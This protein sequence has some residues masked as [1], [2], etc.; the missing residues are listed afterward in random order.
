MN[1]IKIV[2][3]APYY[4][5]VID[6]IVHK[7]TFSD[8]C[9]L[10]DKIHGIMSEDESSQVISLAAEYFRVTREDIM[11][12][13][14]RF[15]MPHIRWV[16]MRVLRD[17]GMSLCDITKVLNLKDH[18]SVMYGLRELPGL[19][20]VDRG[21]SAKTQSFYARL[22]AGGIVSEEISGQ[23]CILSHINPPASLS[24]NEN[25]S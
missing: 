5:L 1:Q 6:G 12:R 10:R 13:S 23:V 9:A 8:L 22:S 18:N 2:Y 3:P 4:E 17:R 25:K 19:L 14:K 24:N 15:G 11:S 21:F 16:I 7:L 20:S